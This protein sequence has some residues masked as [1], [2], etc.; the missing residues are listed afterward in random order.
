MDNVKGV[1]TDKPNE[2]QLYDILLFN[3]LT[4]YYDE[5]LNKARE[6]HGCK[7]VMDLDDDW[8][9][10]HNHVLYQ[11]LLKLEPYIENN[12]RNADMVTC[13][14]ERLADKIFPFNNNVH[15][16]PNAI[17]YGYKQFYTDKVQ[18]DRVRLFWCGSITHE[19]DLALLR[20]PLQRIQ[21]QH[22][23]FKMVIGG[24]TGK[25]PYEKY[26]WDKMVR[27]YTNNLKL[28]HDIYGGLLP[29]MYMELYNF[30][31]IC[32]IPLE[33]SDW[34][35]CKSNLKILESATKKCPVIVSNVEP[36]NVDKDMPVLWANNSADW[37][38]HINYLIN[39]KN[40]RI[41]YGEALHE[42]CKDKYNYKEINDRRRSAF[43]DLIK[44]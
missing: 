41:D 25:N 31:D 39:N 11:N 12:L 20:Y 3:R 37:Y 22:H 2:D 19:H 9:L 5:D 30:A 18:D 36:Y 38:K 7:L 40:A 21:G 32:L 17:P 23:K 13:T 16:F 34:H 33:K 26:V 1:N 43:A 35:A 10:P 4:Y 28:P 14:N 15:I 8:K 44:V 29:S 27:I 42:Y 24:Y 6:T